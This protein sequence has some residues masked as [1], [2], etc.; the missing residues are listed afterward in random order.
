MLNKEILLVM[1]YLKDRKSV[2]ED[3]NRAT[4]KKIDRDR[5]AQAPAEVQTI[6]CCD[7]ISNTRSIV[8][9]GGDFAE[10]YL[11]EKNELIQVMTKATPEVRN[12]AIRQTITQL[13][14]Y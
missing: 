5:L 13:V 2:P 14:R 7:L 6:K 8:A 3:G 10:V 11:K 4:R 12:E 1:E 9:Y